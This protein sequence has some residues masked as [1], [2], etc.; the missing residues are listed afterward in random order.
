MVT[1]RTFIMAKVPGDQK[2]GKQIEISKDL[3][4]TGHIKVGEYS[5][6]LD[7]LEEALAYHGINLKHE[8]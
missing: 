7:E 2:V 5:F 4:H 1:L 3:L 6:K 8:R